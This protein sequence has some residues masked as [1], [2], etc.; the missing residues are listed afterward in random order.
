MSYFSTCSSIQNPLLSFPGVIKAEA[1]SG[2]RKQLFEEVRTAIQTTDAALDLYNKIINKIGT[3]ENVQG[4]RS[5][6]SEIKTRL[7]NGIDLF[8]QSLKPVSKWCTV[9]AIPLLRTYKDGDFQQP[10]NLLQ[11]LND[12]NKIS[13]DAQK[14]VFDSKRSINTAYAYLYSLTSYLEHQ[15]N[16]TNV[17]NVSELNEKVASIREFLEDLVDSKNKILV[18]I[19]EIGDLGNAAA[20]VSTYVSLY[21]NSLRDVVSQ[22]VDN[23]I[24][25]CNN[26]RSN[27]E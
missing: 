17:E 10:D 14:S 11:A 22:S 24:E 26:Y 7:T 16:K 27:N 4:T 1:A 13:N 21:Q 3:T 2:S 6:F 8:K 15:F 12:W 23:L 18:A 20:H 9:Q 5:V 19:Q 25:K